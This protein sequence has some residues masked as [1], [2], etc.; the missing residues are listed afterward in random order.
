MMQVSRCFLERGKHLYRRHLFQGSRRHFFRA[1]IRPSI[2]RGDNPQALKSEIEHSPSCG[3]NIFAHLWPYENN[4][5][6][7]GAFRCVFIY[8]FVLK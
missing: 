3:A 5:R 1:D 6:Q 4:A 8:H 2:T 7:D